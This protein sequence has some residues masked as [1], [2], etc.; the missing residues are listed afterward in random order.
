MDDFSVVDHSV[1]GP[2]AFFSNM[3]L[4]KTLTTNLDVPEPWLVE[5]TIAIHDL[6]NVLLENLGDVSTLQAVFELEALLLTGNEDQWT[7][8]ENRETFSR[9]LQ[10]NKDR[11]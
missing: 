6:D 10:A 2:K 8:K 5:P 1:N 3:P 7:L 9:I 11:L 4:S